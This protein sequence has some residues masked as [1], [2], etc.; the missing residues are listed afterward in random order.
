MYFQVSV[1]SRNDGTLSLIRNSQTSSKFCWFSK[2][3]RDLTHTHTKN[4]N[5][6]NK[7]KKKIVCAQRRLR[8]AWASA[9]SDQSSLSALNKAWVL[10][11][12]LSAQADLSVRWV[13]SHFVGFV[14]SWLKCE[15]NH[16]HWFTGSSTSAPLDTNLCGT[17]L[18][19][20]EYTSTDRYVLVTFTS[21]GSG[22]S[23]G[24]QMTYLSVPDTCTWMLVFAITKIH[25]FSINLI[26]GLLFCFRF[27]RTVHA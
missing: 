2:M 13:H 26:V 11:Y 18:S 5:K 15:T 4:N 25:V 27:I 8:S 6:K 12:P 9:Q 3:S 17:D 24:F 23:Q 19:T 22:V 20:V 10:S 14:M 7:N 16:K 1:I 21:D